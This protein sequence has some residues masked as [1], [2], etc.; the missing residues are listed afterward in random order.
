MAYLLDPDKGEGGG[1]QPRP[2]ATATASLTFQMIRIETIETEFDSAM[3]NVEQI[4]TGL[5]VV[6]VH[7]LNSEGDLLANLGLLDL[8][9]NGDF[10]AGR[11]LL[12]S[13][14]LP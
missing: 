14:R 7:F 4:R 11:L 3:V 8:H 2:M 5:E 9:L 13:R 10:A 1:R 12:L 6:S